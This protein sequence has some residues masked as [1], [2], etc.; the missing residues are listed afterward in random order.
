MMDPL[1]ILGALFSH[2]GKFAG[3]QEA[4]NCEQLQLQRDLMP[5]FQFLQ[6]S[7]PESTERE[8]ELKN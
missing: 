2:P 3:Y 5:V 7:C 1:V 4:D 8:F 6:V